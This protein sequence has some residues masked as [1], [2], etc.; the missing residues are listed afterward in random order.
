[1]KK[2]ISYLFLGALVIGGSVPAIA[3]NGNLSNNKFSITSQNGSIAKDLKSYDINQ[4]DAVASLNSWLDLSNNYT[5]EQISE[6]TDRLGFTQVKYQE[7]FKN[8]AVKD[9]EIILHFRNSKA[10]AINGRI[11]SV[12]EKT[13]TV[14]SLS[15]TDAIQIAK[16]QLNVVQ[17]I[18]NYTPQLYILKD[19][20]T[21]ENVLAWKVRIDGRN[22]KKKLVMNNVYV[23]ANTGK[24]IQTISLITDADVQATAK[25]LYSGTQTITTDSFSGGYRLRDAARK[26]ETYD[27]GGANENPNTSSNIYFDTA[28]D[29]TNVTTT[30]DSIPTLMSMKLQ[31]TSPNFLIGTGSMGFLLSYVADDGFNSLDDGNPLTFNIFFSQ[32]TQANLPIS[33]NGLYLALPKPSYNAGFLKLTGGGD[34]ADS[35]NFKLTDKSIGIHSW[36]DSLGNT[37]TYSMSY[38]KNPALD[39]HWGME[40]THQFYLDK[41]NRDSYDNNGSVLRN[42]INGMLLVSFTQ[43]NAAALPAPYNS[44]VYGLGDG[45]RLGPMVGLDVMGH[46]FTHLVTGNTA[47]LEYQGESGALNESFSD[48]FGTAIEFFAKGNNA[49]W[50]IGEDVM[51]VAP[52]YLRSMSNPKA[53]ASFPNSGTQPQPDT[54]KKQYWVNTTNPSQNNDNGG[55]HTNSGIGN[56]WFYLVSVG[57]TGTNDNN[58]NYNVTGVGIDKAEQIAYRTLTSY[59]TSTSQYIDAYHAS[60]LATGDLY[61]DTSVAYATVKNAWIAVGV[62]DSSTL[63]IATTNPLKDKIELYPNP[64]SGEFTIN[65]S[66]N[67]VLNAQIVSILGVQIKPLEIKKGINKVDISTL[68]KGIYFINME[69]PSGIISEKIILK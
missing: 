38:E 45:Q 6:N 30:W 46:E 32:F 57:G 22:A 41:L 56:K 58:F 5:F 29:I 3:Q 15:N 36:N 62:I 7:L 26:I 66:S 10:T 35:A 43:N 54:Y 33:S 16:E 11:A 17:L 65:N 20:N 23:N 63:G 2:I 59:L 21:N 67:L 39:A 48:M 68:S 47:D 8:I 61:G 24:L 69:T 55:V 44:M 49:N 42:Y 64:T 60:L 1:M 50:L 28:Y 31:T 52:G 9:G 34:I 51:L 13:N 18:N 25:T 14:P 4:K 27:V 19:Y 12:D 40:K 53:P 37:G